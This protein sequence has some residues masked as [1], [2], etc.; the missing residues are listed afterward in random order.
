MSLLDQCDCTTVAFRNGATFSALDQ[1]TTGRMYPVAQ[2]VIRTMNST[3]AIRI[4]GGSCYTPFTLS[5]ADSALADPYVGDRVEL[6]NDR[7][8]Q[9]LITSV[10]YGRKP[11]EDLDELQRM[12]GKPYTLSFFDWGG[13]YG[14]D[15][16]HLASV[17]TSPVR[18]VELQS[19]P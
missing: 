16:K 8:A 17:K 19:H 5:Y 4:E 13:M 15:S 9:D 7:A 14:W 11:V 12:V 1:W 2:L 10:F 3:Y 6:G 18:S